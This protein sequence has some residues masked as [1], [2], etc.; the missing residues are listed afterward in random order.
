MKGNLVA[1]LGFKLG[2]SSI[3]LD[4]PL[5]IVSVA[6]CIDVKVEHLK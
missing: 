2:F 4:C 3:L 5:S 1:G 6:N